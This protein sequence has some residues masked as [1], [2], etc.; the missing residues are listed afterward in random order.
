[1]ATKWDGHW[2]ARGRGREVSLMDT[3]L[4]FGTA[5]KVLEMYGS[6]GHTMVNIF[7]AAQL[8]I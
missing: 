7:N 1:M 2:E 5:K 8:Y 3:E 4:Q 6:D